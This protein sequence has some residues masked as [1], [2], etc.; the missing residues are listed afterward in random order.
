MA[1]HHHA[2]AFFLLSAGM[3]AADESWE[4]LSDGILGRVADFEGVRGVKI[5]G[6]VR[7]PSGDG[8]FPMVMILHGGGP[9]A[10]PVKAETDE[11]RAPLLAAETLRASN[12]LG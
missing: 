10:R 7:R 3:L 1:I 4:K 2:W 8:P 5:A 6:Y 12:Q 9:A 11:A